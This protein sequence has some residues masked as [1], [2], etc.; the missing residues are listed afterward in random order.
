MSK[1]GHGYASPYFIT[2]FDRALAVLDRC[3]ILVTGQNVSSVEPLRPILERT[4][5]MSRSLLLVAAGFSEEVL[6]DLTVE[7]IRNGLRV[8]AVA[9]SSME[10]RQVLDDFAEA[11]GTVVLPSL[12]QSGRMEDLGYAAHV[13]VAKEYTIASRQPVGL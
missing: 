2:D 13:V 12:E 1:F 10:Q 8:C 3:S 7:K 4:A 5:H 6:V 9:A 11:V